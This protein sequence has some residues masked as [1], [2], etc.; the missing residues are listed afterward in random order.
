MMRVGDLCGVF[1]SCFGSSFADAT[2]STIDDSNGWH[3]MTEPVSSRV[4]L[5]Q[6][7]ELPKTTAWHAL[8]PEIHGEIAL[9]TAQ[10]EDRD[11]AKEAVD[12]LRLINHYMRNIVD[13]DPQTQQ[14]YQALRQPGLTRE[15]AAKN[16][17]F[18]NGRDPGEVVRVHAPRNQRAIDEI[19]L[20]QARKEFKKGSFAPDALRASGFDPANR[21]EE[22]S[23]LIAARCD[24]PDLADD[25]KP[26][27]REYKD[28]RATNHDVAN[29]LRDGAIRHLRED[30]N[31]AAPTAISV[32]HVSSSYDREDVLLAAI[33]DDAIRRKMLAPAIIAKHG[34]E[35]A[36]GLPM[37]GF[38]QD[39][40]AQGSF[41]RGA[42]A[43]HAIAANGLTQP[44]KIDLLLK[45]GEDRD[46][47][48]VAPPDV[49]TITT[50]P[51][52][53]LPLLDVAEADVFIWSGHDQEDTDRSD[54]F[55]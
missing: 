10:L 27:T 11:E 9:K 16:D 23:L 34:G 8:P 5:M 18:R 35:Q 40:G 26:E 55:D 4:L 1:G 31:L 12:N 6:Y 13:Y 51:E 29:L 42:R 44:R 37:V 48:E 19:L 30:E 25:S 33:S 45:K 52:G 43:R 7:P 41:E 54:D 46:G 53:S 17:Y 32:G 14:A 2:E 47:P 24:D 20:D 15:D 21:P 49:R 28:L 50:D 38:A 22:G 3:E 39:A 36:L